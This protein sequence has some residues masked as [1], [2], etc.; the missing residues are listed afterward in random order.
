MDLFSRKIV[1]WS[2]GPTIHRELVLD[3]VLMAVRRRRPR[4]TVIHSDQGTQF[5]SDA[6]RRFC[7]SNHLEPSMSRKGQLL[8]QCRRGVLL[9]QFE[10][11]TDQEADLQEPRA[12][13]ERCGRLH[14]SLLQSNPPPQSSWRREPGAV[15]SGPE[16]AVTG[17]PLNPGNSKHRNLQRC[18]RRALETTGISRPDKT[19]DGKR[20]VDTPGAP[21][22]PSLRGHVHAHRARRAGVC[23]GR[24]RRVDSSNLDASDMAVQVKSGGC[25]R[26][27]SRCWESTRHSVGDSPTTSRPGP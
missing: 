9:Q 23:G 15:R 18:A 14:R 2:A 13:V 24:R 26:T 3:A 20:A 6:W 25:R 22:G 8:G 1:G 11:G 27:S 7:R 12:G 17:C 4:G 16:T 21:S 10:E 19:D 5:G